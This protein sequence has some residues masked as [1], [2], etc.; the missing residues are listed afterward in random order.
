MSE[1]YF[2]SG[3]DT[4]CGKTIATGLLARHFLHKG[5][6][7]ITQKL[8]QT[9]CTGIAEDIIT[10]REIMGVDLLEEDKNHLTCP[11]VLGKPS[12]PHLAAEAE[13]IDI[14]MQKI[15]HA[16][17]QLQQ[18][19]DLILLEGAGGLYVPIKRNLLIIDFIKQMNYPLILVSS[20]KVGSINHTMMSLELCKRNHITVSALIYNHF[21]SDDNM[22]IQDSKKI[23]ETYLEANFPG[24]PI[25]DIPNS[26][27]MIFPDIDFKDF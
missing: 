1:I 20:A 26:K 7:I 3:I 14:D 22:I 6:K 27:S 21:P 16:T 13:N 24:V 9:G 19:Y 12:S 25:F 5:K 8:I 11:Y 18:V 15:I 10:H 23:F 2:V 4:D 17:H